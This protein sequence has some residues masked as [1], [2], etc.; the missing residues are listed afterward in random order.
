MPPRFSP[1]F[2][3]SE[4]TSSKVL[5][6]IGRRPN[7]ADLGLDQLGLKLDARGLPPHD[8]TTMQ[9]ADLPIFIAGDANA[10]SPVLHEA[11]DEGRVAGFNAVQK[12]PRRFKR[13]TRLNVVFS[14]PNAAVIGNSFAEIKDQDA[15]IG[16]AR[17][18]RQGRARVMAQNS[19]ILRVCGHKKDGPLLGAEMAAPGGEH[20]AHLLAWLIEKRAT[21]FE[22]L[23]MPFY[24]PV[25][26]KG[27]QS[28]LRD[29]A[30]KVVKKRPRFELA[31]CESSAVEELR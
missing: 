24:H 21:V 26:E 10:G 7:L 17:F 13:R 22:A 16:E 5:A 31:M 28:A 14:E 25:V 30:A 6:A 20:L 19:G 29:L 8:P 3:F 9:A 11:A 18:E 4:T 12:S 1:P 27:L 15:V 23:Q 2:A